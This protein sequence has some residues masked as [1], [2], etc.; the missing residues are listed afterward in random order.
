MWWMT[1]TSREKGTANLLHMIL[2]EFCM[3]RLQNKEEYA[4]LKSRI[5]CRIVF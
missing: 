5:K 2:R 4:R 3:D 1:L